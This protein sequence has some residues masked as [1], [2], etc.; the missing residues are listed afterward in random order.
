MC[1]SGLKEQKSHPNSFTEAIAKRR[2][3][4]GEKGKV[5]ESQGEMYWLKMKDCEKS[6]SS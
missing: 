4:D 1:G 5:S 6:D 2:S 3:V